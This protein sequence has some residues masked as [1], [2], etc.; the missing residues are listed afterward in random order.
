MVGANTLQ[1]FARYARGRGCS[2]SLPRAKTHGKGSVDKLKTGLNERPGPRKPTL[3]SQAESG[4]SRLLLS[5]EQIF[6]KLTKL[7]AA[8]TD[9]KLQDSCARNRSLPDAVLAA[10]LAKFQKERYES[11][12]G[13]LF[14][15][16]MMAKHVSPR[17]FQTAYSMLQSCTTVQLR[18]VVEKLKMIQTKN[19][20]FFLRLS[21]IAN[22]RL[23]D[24]KNVV[25]CLHQFKES[26]VQLARYEVRPYLKA[27]YNIHGLKAHKESYKEMSDIYDGLPLGV[28]HDKINLMARYGLESEAREALLVL[29][30]RAEYDMFCAA[31]I[32]SLSVLGRM[33]ELDNFMNGIPRNEQLL[34]TPVLGAI[35]FSYGIQRMPKKLAEMEGKLTELKHPEDHVARSREFHLEP[36]RVCGGRIATSEDIKDL[37]ADLKL[38]KRAYGIYTLLRESGALADDR[39]RSEAVNLLMRSWTNESQPVSERRN[40]FRGLLHLKAF[41]SSQLFELMH[42]QDPP[43][44]MECYKDMIFAFDKPKD[45]SRFV[46]EGVKHRLFGCAVPMRERLMSLYSM[47]GF[48]E[49][50]TQQFQDCRSQGFTPNWRMYFRQLL[51]LYSNG[52]HDNAHEQLLRMHAD[53]ILLSENE[54]LEVLHILSRSRVA[55]TATSFVEELHAAGVPLTCRTYN[56]LMQILAREAMSQETVT[57][58]QKME[59]RGVA[60]DVVSGYLKARAIDAVRDTIVDPIYQKGQ[61]AERVSDL[62]AQG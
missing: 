33:R 13:A 59:D 12:F 56:G 31:Y 60:K 51:D 39:K 22:C 7:S 46:D 6:A 53:G 44:N 1:E 15:N 23:E 14:E 18:S 38:T 35:R 48:H 4:T 30:Q 62:R 10:I 2:V 25:H 40:A 41:K 54:Y 57:V 49:E 32:R 17:R 3:R 55:E 34:A 9:R 61:E 28:L 27:V 42:R 20:V 58:F 47:R 26:G 45:A 36:A 24:H 21:F 5:Q 16:L 37:V 29:K 43:L 52:D 50:S 11:G 8:E 19:K